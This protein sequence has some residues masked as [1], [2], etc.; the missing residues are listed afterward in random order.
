MMGTESYNLAAY[1]VRSRCS[2]F[3]LPVTHLQY[4]LS[5]IENEVCGFL[6]GYGVRELISQRRRP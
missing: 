3:H 2:I 6:S 5:P 1:S 4:M